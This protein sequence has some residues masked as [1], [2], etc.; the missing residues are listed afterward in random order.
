MIENAT[1]AV[2]AAILEQAADAIIF[3]D[4]EGRIRLWN[5]GAER[6]FGFTAEQALGQSLDLIIPERLRARHW[7]GFDAAIASGATKH[8]GAP[9]RTKGLC[10]SGEPLYVEMTFAVV[11]EPG[12]G[13]VGS[14]AVA[15]LPAGA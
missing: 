4:R 1:P 2:C 11:S 10:R 13:A 6:L 8:Q 15:R 3:A 9:T 5:R 7:A 14:V 12:T